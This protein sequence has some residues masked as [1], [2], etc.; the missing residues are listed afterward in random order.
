MY[1]SELIT[2]GA[3]RIDVRVLLLHDALGLLDGLVQHIEE[4][5]R[6]AITSGDTVKQTLAHTL[7]ADDRS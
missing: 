4:K 3:V 1:L 7:C 2:L 6:L 5:H